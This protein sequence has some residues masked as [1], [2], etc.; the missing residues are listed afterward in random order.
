MRRDD[1][2]SSESPRARLD[3]ATL[4]REFDREGVAV[5]YLFGS[6]LGN[7]HDLSDIDLAYLGTDA[8][9]EERLFDELYEAFQRLLGE[10][11]FDLVPLRRAPLHLQ[12]AIATG[13]RPLLIRF[14]DLAEGFGARAITH[15]LDFKPYRDE[16]FAAKA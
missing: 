7:P 2:A 11:E 14:P 10:G 16:Y 1:R 12:F 15:Y 13:G 9:T 4:A 8:G 6:M 3:L 5:A